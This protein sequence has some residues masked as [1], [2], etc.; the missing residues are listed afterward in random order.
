MESKNLNL[1]YDYDAALAPVQMMGHH[2]LVQAGIPTYLPYIA[3][4]IAVIVLI[5]AVYVMF[6]KDDL[7][8]GLEAG[9]D[10]DGGFDKPVLEDLKENF[11][12]SEG[13]SEDFTEDDFIF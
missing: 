12:W 6:F 11:D 4:G 13:D 8:A 5:Y 10:G 2:L 3:G 1:L 7:D 9:K